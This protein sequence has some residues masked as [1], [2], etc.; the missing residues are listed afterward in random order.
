[1]VCKELCEDMV[2][3][4]GDGQSVEDGGNEWFGVGGFFGVYICCVPDFCVVILQ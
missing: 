2:W 1:M 4:E 3:P